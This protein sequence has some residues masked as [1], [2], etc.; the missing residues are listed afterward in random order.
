MLTRHSSGVLL[1]YTTDGSTVDYKKLFEDIKAHAD[2]SGKRF[3]IYC[4]PENFVRIAAVWYKSVSI[5]ERSQ[6]ELVL[7]THI[8]KER[9]QQGRNWVADDEQYI[10]HV[11]LLQRV[12]VCI[13]CISGFRFLCLHM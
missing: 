12:H 2:T 4:D 6:F 7:N 8:H 13:S 3:F 5:V 11:T 10:V 1:S 9:S